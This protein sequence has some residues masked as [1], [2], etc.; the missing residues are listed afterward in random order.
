[1]EKLKSFFYP[2]TM[3]KAFK[4][5]TVLVSAFGIIFSI[6]FFCL[7]A[8]DTTK[9]KFYNG[10][11]ALILI[12]MIALTIY[13]A[14]FLLLDK[15]WSYSKIYLVLAIGWSI[16]MQFVMPPIS[17]AD[18]VQH[19]YSAYHCSNIYLGIKDHDFDTT[20][21][22]YGNWIEG[23]SYFY[24]RAEDYY[25]LPYIDVTFPYQY[26]I[27]A[28]GNWFHTDDD[29]K[30]LV[31]CYTKP[32]QARRYLLSGL[33][34]AIA[35]LLGFGFSGVV[36]MGR[37]MN[38]L[39]LVLAGWI[40]IKLLPVGKLQLLMF[41]LF[42]TTLQLCS[43][44]SY[45]NMSILFSFI[46]LTTCLYLSQE[47]VKLHAWHIYL[48]AIIVVILIPNKMVYT[49]FAVWFFAIPLK[50]WWTD[51]GKSKK[52][53]E[54]T[55]AGAFIAGAL[56]VV[57]KFAGKYMYILYD[58]F[59]LAHNH[60]TIEQD[61]SRAAYSMYDVLDDPL[62]TLQFA[63]EGIKVD[64][65]YNIHHV[66]GS[67]LGHIKLNA[68][69]PMA[70]VVTMLIVLILGLIINKG[71]RLKKWQYVII[72]LGLLIC[73]VAIFAGCLVRFTPAEGSERIQISYRYL[74]PV[75]MCMC[76]ALGTDAKEDKKALAL[77]LI[78]NVALM[79]GLCGTIY[80]LLHLRDGMAAPEILNAIGIY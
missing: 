9:T 45:D 6:V 79:V 23:T 31:Q 29:M 13:L 57:K 48:I 65:W 27:L 40:C 20:P 46:L 32:T 22:S 19:F 34:I 49:L 47:N 3:D 75:Y 28:D 15:E 2:M 35:R 7:N 74:I 21:G 68:T 16:C 36:F 58:M 14:R 76:I 60:A 10:Y 25:K 42:P 30:E 12:V 51:V 72:G 52:W 77:I 61:A 59:V 44:Y 41:S 71:K 43:S 50:K 70:C 18:E 80:F 38:S 8:F 78:Q 64:F 5:G 55:L 1:M 56:L 37:I 54:Y 69:V 39:T 17:G 33:G 73:V 11:F 24:M 66:I 63:W 53:Y 26:Q 4:L 67:E 62:G